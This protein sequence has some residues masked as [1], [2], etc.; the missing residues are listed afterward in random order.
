M[1]NPER[2]SPIDL[3]HF[4]DRDALDRATR[5]LDEAEQ[6]SRPAEISQAL[7]QIARGHRALG[8]LA[9][10]EWYLNRALRWA[11]TLGGVD[12]SVDLLCDL[13][14]VAESI[15]AEVA[16]ADD[17]CAH[18]A[19]DRARDHGFE[20]T[21]LARQ[22]ADPSWEVTVLMRVSDVLDRCGDHHDAIELHRRAMTLITRDHL[23][24]FVATNQ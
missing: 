19:R 17:R 8:L 9:A 18:A 20:A 5:A 22:C 24:R 1:M 13:A 4:A 3:L 7:A 16:P 15:A 23:C 6:R 11:R 21:R 10:S 2:P 12:A 14:E